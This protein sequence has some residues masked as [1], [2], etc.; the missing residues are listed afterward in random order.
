M[1]LAYSS[2]CVDVLRDLYAAALAASARMD[3]RLYHYAGRAAREE[4]LADL[5]RFIESVGNLA[6]GHGHAILRENVFC[7]I[8]VNFHKESICVVP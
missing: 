2:A 6:S 1:F 5:N 3:L 7:L 8:F 4:A